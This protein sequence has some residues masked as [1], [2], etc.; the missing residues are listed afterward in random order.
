MIKNKTQGEKPFKIKWL[1]QYISILNVRLI[2]CEIYKP[3]ICNN[4]SKRATKSFLV[5]ISM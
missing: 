4:N 1:N 3:M 2:E 5:Y